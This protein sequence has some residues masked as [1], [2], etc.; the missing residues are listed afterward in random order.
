MIDINKREYSEIWKK[1][2]S[3]TYFLQIPTTSGSP[4][5]KTTFYF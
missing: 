1:S 2:M 3:V 4:V 5:V